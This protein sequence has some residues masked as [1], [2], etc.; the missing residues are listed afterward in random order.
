LNV[1]TLLHRKCSQVINTL[2]DVRHK[3]VISVLDF[4]NVKQ[5]WC[6]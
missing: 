3:H 4:T 2:T 1:T 6:F 5:H